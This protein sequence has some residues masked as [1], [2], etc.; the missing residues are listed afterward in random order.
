MAKLRKSLREDW[1]LLP[2]FVT[3]GLGF[4]VAVL[5]FVFL[6]T[7][8]FQLFALAGCAFILLGGYVRMKAR[9]QLRTKAGFPSLAATGRLQTVDGH[10]LVTD[11][12]YACIRHP[13]Y[14]GETVRNFRIVVIFSSL[15]G[16][17]LIGAATLFL[18]FRIRIEEQMLLE[19]FGETYAEYQ[20]N[21]KRLIP[22][23]Y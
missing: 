10:Q 22:C 8:T 9:L 23:I 21:T 6:Q 15:Y 1:T 13:I 14:L 7:L 2:F 11:G 20:R 3:T 17:A 19:V 16:M 18:V 12:L 4:L 5:D